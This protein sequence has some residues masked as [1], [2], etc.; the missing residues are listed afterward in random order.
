MHGIQ[1][2]T[3]YI[4]IPYMYDLK[5]LKKTRSLLQSLQHTIKCISTSKSASN[6]R[7]FLALLLANVLG[8]TF[9][10]IFPLARWLRTRGFR[11]PTVRPAEATNHWKWL[12]FT[13][14]L[15][16]RGPLFS[17]LLFSPL[18]LLLLFPPLLFMCPYGRKFDV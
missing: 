11:E 5:I 8:A 9:A 18:L 7:C 3:I 15:P 17:S 6:L 4:Y 1:T 2:Y 13:T 12:C 14:F 10:C 16:F